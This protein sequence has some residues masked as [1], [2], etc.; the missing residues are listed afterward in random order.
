MRAHGVRPNDEQAE[1]GAAYDH[2]VVG[3]GL[4]GLAYAWRRHREGRRVLVLEEAGAALPTPPALVEG[5]APH[6]ERLIA[7]VPSAE[8]LETPACGPRQIWTPGGLRPAVPST[9]QRL[10]RRPASLAFV[11]RARLASAGPPE[12]VALRVLRGGVGA[13]RNALIEALG[14][15]ERVRIGP[16]VHGVRPR[17]SANPNARVETEAGT[18]HA[19]EVALDLPPHEQARLLAAHAPHHADVLRAVSTVEVTEVT[20]E[21]GPDV[22]PPI[23]G[24][25]RGMDVRARM[26]SALFLAHLA[27]ARYAPGFVEV[28]TEAAAIEAVEAEALGRIALAELARALGRPVRG[29]FVGTES[30]RRVRAEPGHRRRMAQLAADLGGHGILLLGASGLGDDLDRLAV[31]GV[32]LAG[33]LPEGV[34]IA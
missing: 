34:T 30:T 32:P 22:L 14:G 7:S 12:P 11:V 23:A 21:V 29:R 33:P 16:A 27:P 2:V 17:V 5:A 24:F 28:S 4:S 26:Q 15:R 8:E 1:S 10:L 25:V 19:R 3:A 9:L 31:A 20:V 18:L 13:L 6:L